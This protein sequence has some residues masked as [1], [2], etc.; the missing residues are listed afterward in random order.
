MIPLH[1]KFIYLENK[2]FNY[3]TECKNIQQKRNLTPEIA[4]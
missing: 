2:Y 3:L 1:Q 4:F